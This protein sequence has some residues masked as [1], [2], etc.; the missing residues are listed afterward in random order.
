M[1]IAA[2]I[3]MI[4]AIILV[5]GGLAAAIVHLRRHPSPYTDE[6]PDDNAVAA[7]SEAGPEGPGP[8]A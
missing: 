3:M 4:F 7:S 2:I 5:W 6:M 8:R 1:N